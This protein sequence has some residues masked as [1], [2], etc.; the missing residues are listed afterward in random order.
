MIL[1]IY[2]VQSLDSLGTLSVSD[3]TEPVAG[4][5]LEG[6]GREPSKLPG[7]LIKFSLE[8]PLRQ[9]QSQHCAVLHNRFY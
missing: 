6:T 7:C 3:V 9:G 5:L 1:G 2:L 8:T 4:K